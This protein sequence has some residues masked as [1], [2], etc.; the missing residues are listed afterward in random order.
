MKSQ[1][2]LDE[3]KDT[4]SQLVNHSRRLLTV[5]PELVAP[6][7]T[8]LDQLRIVASLYPPKGCNPSDYWP[9]AIET[10]HTKTNSR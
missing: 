9:R 1:G 3:D 7:A 5:D 2:A 4:E 6:A 10:G 8:R